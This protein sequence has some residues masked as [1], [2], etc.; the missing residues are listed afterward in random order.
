VA[1]SHATA[2]EASSSFEGFPSPEVRT[3]LE[4]AG[5]LAVI[6]SRSDPP[7]ANPT[8]SSTPALLARLPIPPQARSLFPPRPPPVPSR[9][10]F[11]T[12]RPLPVLTL[13]LSSPRRPDPSRTRFGWLH[14]DDAQRI[15]GRL[16]FAARCSGRFPRPFQGPKTS[17]R[18]CSTPSLLHPLRSVVPPASPFT[19]SQVSPTPRPIL[20]WVFAPPELSPSTPGPSNPPASRATLPPCRFP[21]PRPKV[22][23]SSSTRP[24]RT[25]HTCTP[26]DRRLATFTDPP[27]RTDLGLDTRPKGPRDPLR[28]VSRPCAPPLRAN[29]PLRN[30]DPTRQREPSPRSGWP[31]PPLGGERDSLGL[32]VLVS[33]RPRERERRPTS[34]PDPRSF[35]VCEK[36]LI[37]P[38]YP[39]ANARDCLL[40]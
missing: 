10:W 38:A 3:P 14:L 25:A 27:K 24:S 32:L 36:R 20:P 13:S 1:L 19:L 33:R 23:L 15:E 34:T 21:R 22:E 29:P 28:R 40:S 9:L 16:R 7:Q 6:H 4:A 18:A 30:T 26:R 31:A 5:F 8:V 17:S 39:K 37:P 2:T 11:G 12:R 35:A